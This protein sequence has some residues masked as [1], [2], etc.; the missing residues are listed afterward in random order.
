MSAAETDPKFRLFYNHICGLDPRLYQPGIVRP[1]LQLHTA[2]VD[3]LLDWADCVH[4]RNTANNLLNE[5]LTEYWARNGMRG[6]A[7]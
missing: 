5:E 7:Q 6:A 1:G 3:A 2:L 4:A